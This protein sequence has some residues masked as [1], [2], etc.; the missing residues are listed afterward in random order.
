M[1]RVFRWQPHCHRRGS[2]RGVLIAAPTFCPTSCSSTLTSRQNAKQLQTC[3]FTTVL[4]CSSPASSYAAHKSL[5][6]HPK[7]H[8]AVRSFLNQ[9]NPLHDSTRRFCPRSSMMFSSRLLPCTCVP[10][11]PSPM[12][13]CRAA[14]SSNR[15]SRRH[16]RPGSAA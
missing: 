8:I 14:P 6:H 11:A 9:K 15:H 7:Q 16:P 3:L 5:R 2:F 12:P 1:A 13:A 10:H 4:S